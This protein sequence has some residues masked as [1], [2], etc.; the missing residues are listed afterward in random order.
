M[1]LVA[2]QNASPPAVMGVA[3]GASHF[4]RVF[5]G[6]LMLPVLGA[7]F[8]SR[9]YAAVG[10]SSGSRVLGQLSP[11]R[12]LGAGRGLPPAAAQQLREAFASA[13]PIVFIVLLPLIAIAFACVF[14][15][16]GRALESG[17]D[18]ASAVV[19]AVEQTEAWAAPVRS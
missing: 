19:A 2:V 10:E 4:S 6:A 13:T 18:E 14:L 3:S 11:Q 12:L 5:A 1:F 8:A 16:D 7:L 9:L 15:I 17:A